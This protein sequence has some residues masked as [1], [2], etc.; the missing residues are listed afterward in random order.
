VENLQYIYVDDESTTM[1]VLRQGLRSRRV[2]S[3]QYNMSSSRSHAIFQMYLDFEERDFENTANGTASDD[4]SLKDNTWKTSADMNGNGTGKKFDV[5][6]R[7]LTF[8]DLAG[9][10]R[11]QT[12]HQAKSKT[13]FK[14]SVT[15][16][17]SISALGNC[18]QALA[19]MSLAG[20]EAEDA[21]GFLTGQA[22]G[23][24][25]RASHVPFRDC[26]LT[27]LLAEPLGGNS[28]TC[29]IVNIGPCSYNYE[30]TNSTMKFA[31]R[32]VN[33]CMW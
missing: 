25:K 17:K 12:H 31:R 8:V 24:V 20:E 5:R 13:Q 22:T 30:E 6:R 27:R 11:V 26:K 29:I 3:T 28:K 21:N 10:E 15:I 32:S 33:G 1:D 23:G 2:Q 4:A 16:N 18:I 7:V 19:S 9:S 14:E